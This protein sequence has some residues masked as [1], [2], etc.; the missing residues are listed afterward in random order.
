[1]NDTYKVVPISPPEYNLGD[2]PAYKKTI[3]SI[4]HQENCLYRAIM[5]RL[6]HI[7][8]KI[9][10]GE[11]KLKKNEK[12]DFLDFFSKCEDLCKRKKYDELA[13]CLLSKKLSKDIE[14]KFPELDI[15]RESIKVYKRARA[16]VE[17]CVAELDK[18]AADMA[19]MPKLARDLAYDH[20]RTPYAIFQYSILICLNDGDIATAKEMVDTFTIKRQKINVVQY[21]GVGFTLM[22]EF[23]LDPDP[24]NTVLGRIHSAWQKLESEGKKPENIDWIAVSEKSAEEGNPFSRS[25]TYYWK[26]GLI[27]TEKK[28]YELLKASIKPEPRFDAAK[29]KH[30]GI[31]PEIDL[32]I[33]DEDRIEIRKLKEDAYHKL[34]ELEKKYE[35]NAIALRVLAEIRYTMDATIASWLSAYV[36]GQRKMCKVYETRIKTITENLDVLIESAINES[37][38]IRKMFEEKAVETLREKLVD[39][40]VKISPE[41]MQEW[42]WRKIE[43]GI[44]TALVLTSLPGGYNSKEIAKMSE[45]EKTRRQKDLIKA[46]IKT[47]DGYWLFL[48]MTP[49]SKAICVREGDVITEKISKDKIPEI[50]EEK[51]A[52]VVF[53]DIIITDTTISP[54]DDRPVLKSSLMVYEFQLIDGK[55]QYVKRKAERLTGNIQFSFYDEKMVGLLRRLPEGWERMKWDHREEYYLSLSPHEFEGKNLELHGWKKTSTLPV[56]LQKDKVKIEIPYEHLLR[57]Q[58]L[59]IGESHRHGNYAIKRKEEYYTIAQRRKKIPIVGKEYEVEINVPIN[60]MAAIKD[61]YERQLTKTPYTKAPK[62]LEKV[63]V[64]GTTINFPFYPLKWTKAGMDYNLTAFG[65]YAKI[66]GGPHWLVARPRHCYTAYLNIKEA[67]MQIDYHTP[68][69]SRVREVRADVTTTTEGGCVTITTEHYT[70]LGAKPMT[71]VTIPPIVTTGEIVVS[72]VPTGL[73]S[74]EEANLLLPSGST[75][76]LKNA[77]D[78]FKST[79]DWKKYTDALLNFMNTTTPDGRKVWE[80]LVTQ[81]VK[82]KILREFLETRNVTRELWAELKKD[83]VSTKNVFGDLETLPIKTSNTHI[84]EVYKLEFQ[85]KK[86]VLGIIEIVGLGYSRVITKTTVQIKVDDKWYTPY[87]EEKKTG[88]LPVN[89]TAKVGEYKYEVTYAFNVN[90]DE[91]VQMF[92]SSGI[93]PDVLTQLWDIVFKEEKSLWALRKFGRLIS[94]MTPD[95]ITYLKVGDRTSLSLNWYGPWISFDFVRQ[96]TNAVGKWIYKKFYL[97][98]FPVMVRGEVAWDLVWESIEKQCLKTLDQLKFSIAAYAGIGKVLLFGKYEI[99]RQGQVTSWNAGVR[100]SLPRNS[101]LELSHSYRREPIQGELRESKITF[102]RLTFRF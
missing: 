62:Y 49:I 72:S 4:A 58:E 28:V 63:I 3:E 82:E 1:M 60:Y 21:V 55:W 77:Y 53:P 26:G 102:L 5:E 97:P 54:K 61:A 70:T 38:K 64:D 11:I 88:I 76:E 2:Y 91:S 81:G 6:E 34:R 13:E 37:K 87:V 44:V 14:E 9:E 46:G 101:S 36:G 79:G 85:P 90:G 74:I 19:K 98:Y 17:Q 39:H 94:A 83:G 50:L 93:E 27:Q 48:C 96:V 52:T 47:F 67:E 18:M 42:H 35:Y 20:S 25:D 57:A 41:V 16:F 45:E 68:D 65:D 31:M 30:P 23:Y 80:L 71:V 51:L 15:D 12:E 95:D 8:L 99:P 66:D 33:R 89:I 56:I 59:E 69:E 7:K 84:M 22:A 40:R 86:P 32:T 100:I 29:F 73:S 24:R 92:K 43:G 10:S 78:A 75:I